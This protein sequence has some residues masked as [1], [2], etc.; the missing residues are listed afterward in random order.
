M[1]VVVP[2]LQRH[3]VR[4]A[5]AELEVPQRDQGQLDR[6][7][8]ALGRLWRDQ[9]AGVNQVHLRRSGREIR[10]RWIAGPW[11]FVD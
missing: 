8:V 10:T 3:Y 1:R 4:Q 11:R 7:K 6:D 5:T 2:R 9:D